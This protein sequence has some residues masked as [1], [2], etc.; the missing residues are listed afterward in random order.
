MNLVSLGVS[1]EMALRFASENPKRYLGMET[2][3][4]IRML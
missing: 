1:Q 3:E 4:R 2:S